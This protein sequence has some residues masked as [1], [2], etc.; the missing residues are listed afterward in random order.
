[1]NLQGR[2]LN[3]HGDVQRI[4]TDSNQS[5]KKEKGELLKR[6]KNLHITTGVI[7]RKSL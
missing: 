7:G 4:F 5:G 1:V 6:S 2:E 3:T